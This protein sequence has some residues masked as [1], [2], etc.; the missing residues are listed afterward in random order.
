MNS[1][2]ALLEGRPDRPLSLALLAGTLT[3]N[4]QKNEVKGP[5]VCPRPGLKDQ[6]VQHEIK[7]ENTGGH[8]ETR[9][10]AINQGTRPHPTATSAPSSPN[11]ASRPFGSGV[12]AASAPSLRP[13]GPLP[14]PGLPGSGRRPRRE[15]RWRLPSNCATSPGSRPGPAPS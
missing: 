3:P 15:G 10:E 5:K 2:A 13:G 11:P 9:R 8:G 12:F 6:D 4:N 1:S 7:G 14:A